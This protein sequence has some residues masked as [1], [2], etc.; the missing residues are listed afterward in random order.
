[1]KDFSYRGSWLQ[2]RI[3]EKPAGGNIEIYTKGDMEGG[4]KPT[5]F[6]YKLKHRQQKLPVF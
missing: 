4:S 5:V 1:M 6:P 2:G 3:A